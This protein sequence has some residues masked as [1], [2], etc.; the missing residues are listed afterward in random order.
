M[1][2]IELHDDLCRDA[3]LTAV[4]EK[5]FEMSRS[6]ELTVARRVSPLVR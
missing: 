1:F 2:I 5:D 6:G 4:G 3:F